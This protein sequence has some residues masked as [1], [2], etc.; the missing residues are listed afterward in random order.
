[1]PSNVST[2]IEIQKKCIE[3]KEQ[4][5]TSREIYLEYFSPLRPNMSYETFRRTLKRWNR[6]A[7][8]NSDLLQKARLDSSQIAHA[9]TIQLGANGDIVQS[10]IR[11]KSFDSQYM[12]LI[13]EIKNGIEPAFLAVPPPKDPLN[14]MLEI[15]PY[16]MHFGINTLEDYRETLDE[17][18][19]LL[20]R[21]Y[22]RVVIVIGQDLFH[23]DDFRGRTTSG[24][25]IEKVDIVRAWNDAK[26]F[27]TSIIMASPVI[28][29]IL[30][31][32]GNHDETLGWAFVQM[33]KAQFPQIKVDDSRRDR[34]I[35]TFGENVIG[36]THGDKVKGRPINLRSVFSVE[37]PLEFACAKVKE[38]HAGHLHHEKS[39]DIYG[40]MC[41][42]LSTANQTDDWHYDNGFVG[43]NK[44][45][46]V[47]E[48]SETKL[49]SIHYI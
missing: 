15:A 46:M 37:Y 44:R 4:G 21:P 34:K 16:D 32:Q 41:R 38:I 26:I 23:N 36:I 40:V 43:Q 25:P 45:F 11:T 33:L 5:K 3:L 17:I 35:I 10:W 39:E 19:L 24:T 18:L 31:S 7:Y 48:W 42:T 8:P 13:D 47:F 20:N 12:L 9:S 28:P 49:C 6:K 27:F 2:P 14:R 29:E 22:Q 30:Y 1:M